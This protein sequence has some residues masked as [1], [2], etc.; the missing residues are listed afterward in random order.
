M[1]SVDVI[2]LFHCA[3]QIDLAFE[4]EMNHRFVSFQQ[5]SNIRTPTQKII[6]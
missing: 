2:F 1:V 6:L 5:E 4:R 3:P